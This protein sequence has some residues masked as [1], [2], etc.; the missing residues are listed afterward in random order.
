VRGASLHWL[1]EDAALVVEAPGAAPAT[2]SLLRNTAHATVSQLIGERRELRP[3]ENTLTLV[4]GIIGAYPNAFLRVSPAQLPALAEAIRG[5]KSEA[6]YTA[7]AERYA[8]RRTAP[9]FWAV[10]D[11]L[12]DRYRRDQPLQAGVL[13]LNRYENR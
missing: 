12:V 7:F 1:P 2:F 13:D 6:D 5:L 3:E 9:D 10:S 8:V 11:G 4:P